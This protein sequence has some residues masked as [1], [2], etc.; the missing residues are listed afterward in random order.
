[1]AV[2]VVFLQVGEVFKMKELINRRPSR[3]SAR[4][5]SL[6]ARSVQGMFESLESRQMMSLL[7]V[8]PTYP[9]ILVQSSA[10][11]GI[12]YT[13]NSSSG[14]GFFATS[15][16]VQFQINSSAF[17]D[18]ISNGNL[19]ISF[20]VGSN[21][22]VLPNQS[23]PN[24][25]LTGTATNLLTGNVDYSG[26]LLEGDISR[27]GFAASTGTPPTAAF[28]FD[29]KINSDDS[30]ALES[31]YSGG[32]IGATFL[33]L[34]STFTGNFTS[35]FTG[36]VN[37]SVGALPVPSIN[38]S[39]QPATATVGSS[40]A[41]KATVTGGN[42]PTGTVTFELFANSTGTGTP[43]YTDAN[44]PLSGG[45]ATSAGY[46]A[47]ATGTDYWVAIYNGDGNNGSVTSGTASEP[48][49]I[50]PASPAINTSQQP[51]TATV[52]SS[53]AD[54]ATVSG[55][56]NPSGTVTFDL[57]NNPN[58]AGTVLFADTE[59]LSGGI[60]TSKGYIA[61]ATG[62]DYWVAIY[63]GNSNNA[64]VASGTALEPVVIT[65]ASPAINTSQQPATAVV[66]SSIADKATVTGGYNPTGTV[67]FELFANSTGTGTPLYTDTGVALVGGSATSV[68][69]TATAAGTDYWVAT[70]NGDSNNK[71]V[72]SGTA[73]EPVVITPA[74]PTIS[75]VP[76]G[77]VQLGEI[78][79]SGT[80][81]L[82]LTGNGFSSDDTPQGGVTIDLYE[83]SNGSNGLQT[84]SGGDT[85]IG[86]TTTASNG[87]YSFMV[88]SAGTYYVTEVVPA[89][90]IQTG[91]G[92]NG[93]A[94][95]TY[96]T[97]TAAAN[98]TYGGNNFDD[99]MIPTC[100]PT[101]VYF[102]VTAP[103]GSCQIV[104]NLAGNTQQ[105]DTVTAYFTVTAG[106]SDQ[107]TLVSYI[108][109]G[110]SFSDA[111]A[112]QQL[113][114][115]Q[116]TGTFSAG[117]YS[118]TVQIPKSYYQIDFVCGASITQLE[119]NQ[120][121]D[122]YGPDSANVLYH[123]E[124]RFI[125]S[126]N[127]GTTVPTTLNTTAPDAP[128]PTVTSAG[129]AL[130]D[131]ATLAGGVNPTG[132]IT[133]TLYNPSNVAVYTDVVTVSGN[134]TYTVAGGNNPGG[135]VPTVAGTYEWV[136]SY[137][138]DSNNKAVASPEGSEPEVVS[139]PVT[140]GCTGSVGFWC[141]QNG[142]SLICCL[143][144]GSNCTNLGNWLCNNY[145][146]LYGTGCGSYCLSGKSNSYICNLIKSL[147]NNSSTQCNAQVLACAINCYVTNSTLCGTCA[148]NYGFTVC[149][150]GTG[151]MTWD[152]GTQLAAYGGPEGVICINTLL[153]LL[154]SASCNGNI[155]SGNSSLQN[156][157]NSIF[158]GIN[159][160]GGI[161]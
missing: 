126:D 26:T 145:G 111:T 50:T 5:Q 3:A 146:N 133:F 108:A 57:Y 154:N 144:G 11:Q 47:T 84:G 86:Q 37:G 95:C 97:I 103:N 35:S 137:G 121:N 45:T 9:T 114:Y 38:T 41:D 81:Y 150:G 124:D 49:V 90:Y 75:T 20:Q 43:L 65:P 62:T 105:G 102:K 106:M 48:V 59:N 33:S 42:N 104:T 7:G 131:S 110:S 149:S 80:K 76:G 25:I 107:L 39:Q 157:C 155:C 16:P 128:T 161:C 67:T 14:N 30:G 72:I 82:D 91:G 152:I 123:A 24:L 12:N 78:T 64:S 141:G 21:G 87:T 68:G 101:N 40:I 109:P 17:P 138:G 60:A 129:T 100:A 22:N 13:Y 115:Q 117:C 44:V 139:A 61:T 142:Q 140:C 120:N 98:H 135:Y 118:L 28:D 19:S 29:F 15:T 18:T 92:P 54:K 132:T 6:V 85:L 56:Y 130:T 156:L 143:N 46:T 99:Y 70:Y 73:L 113:I 96:Y 134:G 10:T 23:G 112:Y 159:Q 69:Y 51:A 27:F 36:G 79:I 116:A 4:Q 88:G 77:P 93:T 119:P 125:S 58:G 158:C 89:G 147:N 160:C 32:D 71:S 1:V 34:G 2:C 94:G 127:G 55:G 8:T 53:I 66:G 148:C 153:Q 136:A 151:Q 31:L 52:G 122:V 83:A 63:N 74:S